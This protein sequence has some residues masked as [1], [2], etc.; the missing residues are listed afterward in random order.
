MYNLGNAESY[1]KQKATLYSYA[2]HVGHI[3]HI[4]HTLISY[5]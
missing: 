3:I 5:S 1:H 4:T 2:Y